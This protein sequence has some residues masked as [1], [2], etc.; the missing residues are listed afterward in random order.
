LCRTEVNV[1]LIGG[2]LGYHLLKRISPTGNAAAMDGSAYVGKSKLELLLGPRVWDLTRGKTVLDFGCGEGHE[3]VELAERGAGLVVGLD[4]RES[5]LSVARA[6]ARKAGVADRC[7]FTTDAAQ[8]RADVIVSTD[9]FEHFSDPAG[10]LRAM[11]AMLAPEGSVL[12]SF[13]PTWYHPLGGHL[14]SVFPWAHLIFTERAFIRWR[15][16]FKHDGATRFS[17][18]A[19]GLN[20][21]T[22]RRFERLVAA[23]P[24]RFAEMEPVPIRRLRPVANRL[25]REWTTATVRCRL[26]RR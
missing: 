7:R 4:I 6:N 16:D 15:S 2:A 25:T 24:L 8:V 10:V 19:G 9:A 1:A 22:I 23:S 12:A 17:E 21:M 13:G 3:A 18:V 26:V 11:S 5:A 20:Q 14:F